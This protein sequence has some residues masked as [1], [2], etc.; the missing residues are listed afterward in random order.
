MKAL[1]RALADRRHPHHR[2]R[3]IVW[4]LLTL[5]F[6]GGRMSPSTTTTG[7]GGGSGGAGPSTSTV[8]LNSPA[9]LNNIT[10]S[11]NVVKTKY[12]PLRGIVFRATP[13]VIEGFLGVPYASPPIGSLR[14]MPPVTPSTWK[15]T[16]LVDRYAPVCP[17]KLPK[18]D[19]PGDPGAIGELPLDRLKQL[20]RLVPTLVNQSEDCLY[21]NLYVPHADDTPHRLDH[22]KPTIVYIHGESYEWNSGNHY[23]GTTLAMNGNVIVVTINFRLGV[24]GFLKTGAKGSAQ[25]NFGLMDLVAGLH[26]LRENLVAFG[27]DPAKITLMGHGTGAALANILAVSPVAGDL[28]HRVVLLS[29]SALSPWAIQR[30]PLAVKRKVAEQTSC[31][32]DVVNE[33]L[34]PCL[35][36]KSLAELMN[37]SLSSPRFLPGFAPFVDG[38][39]ITQAKAA[40]INNLKIPSDSAIASTSGIE[41][42]N[43]H[44]QDVLFGLT[45]YESYLELTAADLEFGFNETKR[46]RIL[47][48]FVRNTYRYHLNEIYSAL[49]NEYTNWERSPR[50][51]YG[52]RDAVLELLSDGL[53]AAPLV[54]LSHLHSLQGG[55]SYFL[56]FKHQS[57]EWK[58]PQRAGSVRGEDVPFAL[59]FSPSPMFPLTLTRLDMQ[60]SSTVM[61]YLCNFVK[62]GNPNGLRASRMDV[63]VNNNNK[64][65]WNPAK[66]SP[67]Y[68]DTMMRQ[69]VASFRPVDD[70]TGDDDGSLQTSRSGSSAPSSQQQ[71]QQPV[72][73]QLQQTTMQQQQH[74][75]LLQYYHKDT[76]Q[77]KHLRKK[78]KF[79]NDLQRFSS[80]ESPGYQSSEEESRGGGNGDGDDRGHSEDD[81][82]DEPDGTLDSGVGRGDETEASY[83][84]LNSDNLYSG[85]TTLKYN[86]PFWGHYDTTN[87]VFMEIG[88][89]VVP[90]SH[91]R[92]HKL[93]LWLSL[94]PQLHSSFN[95]PELSMRHHHF[96]EVDPIFYDGLVREQIIEPPMVH[97]G[98]VTSTT[99]KMHKTETIASTILQSI[100]TECPPNIT[101]IQTASASWPL[102]NAA[103]PTHHSDSNRSLINRLT[104]SYQRSYSTALAITI[105]VGCFLLFLNVL[106][107]VA[108][109]YQREKRE[110][111][112]RM[113]INLLELESRLNVVESS[114]GAVAAAVAASS[115]STTT[116]GDHQLGGTKGAMNDESIS[117]ASGQQKVKDGDELYPT[118]G[119]TG[120]KHVAG[121]VGVSI[122]TSPAPPPA[123]QSGQSNIQTIELSLQ[124][125]YGHHGH[126]MSMRRSSTSAIKHSHKCE[127]QQHHQHLQQHQHQYGRSTVASASSANSRV[128]VSPKK[129]S[130]ISPNP[131]D[132]QSSSGSVSSLTSDQQVPAVQRETRSYSVV[133]LPKE[134]CNQSTQYD[135]AELSQLPLTEATARPLMA[136]TAT[137]TRRRDLMRDDFRKIGATGGGSTR[138]LATRD[139]NYRDELQV[140]VGS[141][142]LRPP[143]MHQLHHHQHQ[144]LHHQ[145]QQ[146]QQPPSEATHANN[147]KRVQ[148]QE[149]SV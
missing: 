56:H 73:L 40:I 46:D 49:K 101:F 19:G 122:K 52:Y 123:S 119:G 59:G 102:H 98:F 37:I 62:T 130:I 131:S 33:D 43:F 66:K 76:R 17:Q 104:N 125:H 11:N 70:V 77:Q 36:T 48:T 5:W 89:K 106:I 45:T 109:Y 25:G 60:V 136:S 51:A 2:Q 103:L 132:N 90:K 71:Q 142:I 91:Y 100:S 95:I 14:Y 128:T 93:S 53:T 7:L 1:G 4:L 67:Q 85:F 113:K 75:L 63:F 140:H 94:I 32:G 149:I 29:G 22:L 64:R 107:F 92:G 10:Y 111:N 44:K 13:M 143:S 115:T 35:R 134:L 38:T 124:P 82:E 21:L 105:G 18:L 74:Q 15:F 30:D 12:G 99:S 47:R 24:L 118:K 137:M 6:T 147:K 39:V 110:S 65:S 139:Y 138:S 121:G 9:S 148:I 23:D 141:G 8:G 78:R 3:A 135:L 16:R 108:I 84:S 72:A 50:S 31:T 83:Y 28:I 87:Q 97:I 58:F 80:A 126:A 96:S 146:Q 120:I 54:Q 116:G 57:H 112:S 133:S 81:G 127:L 34:A 114:S 41:F 79:S 88:S 129:V 61:R 55:R 68:N 86:L 42:S 69:L 27:G 20:R 144:H 145:Q 117:S 26:W